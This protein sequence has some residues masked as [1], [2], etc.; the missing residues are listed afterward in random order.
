MGVKATFYTDTKLI[1]LDIVAPVSSRVAIDTQVDLYSDAKEDWQNEAFQKFEFPFTT[2]GGNDLGGGLEAGDYYFLRTD[3]GWRIRPYEADHTLTIT[4]NLYPIDS[5]D[6]LVVPTSTAATVATIFERSQLTQTVQDQV[7][8]TAS[9]V[10]AQPVNGVTA[11][12]FGEIMR[13]QAFGHAVYF[14]GDLG[15]AGTAYPLGTQRYPVNNFANAFTIAQAESAPIVHME[16][17]GVILAT[18]DATGMIIEGHH[19]LKVQ[20]QVSAGAVTTNTQF[21]ELYLRN[22]ALNGWV[23]VRDSL[24]ENITGFQ[25]IAHQCMLNPGTIQLTGAQG[26]HFLECFSGQPG[27]STP[28]IDV[29]GK[30]VD[31]GFRA[32]SGGIRFE[33]NTANN[34]ISVDL[35]SGQI[36]LASTCTS[37]TFVARGTGKLVDNAGNAIPSGAWNG[38]IVVNE[39]TS[40]AG[41]ALTSTQD[42]RLRE[43][44]QI[45]GLEYGAPLI[46]T[47][48]TRA[49]A[50]VTQAITG[51]PE[52]AITITRT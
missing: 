43:L 25:G 24:L 22:A 7:S 34:N 47:A 44:H 9:A 39:T 28:I 31:V 48:S 32:Y 4:G 15:A 12:S 46:T 50:S 49:A 51:D 13:S 52:S 33:N 27:T 3:L 35:L 14:D 45:F 20:C 21:R 5:N 37:G 8:Q 10:W 16:S 17:E 40:N 11:G 19:P 36:V 38:M 26:S 2:I 1:E 29:N 41:G 6:D 23:V 42:Q 18:D 30:N